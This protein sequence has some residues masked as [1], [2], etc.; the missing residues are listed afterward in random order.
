MNSQRGL[1]GVSMLFVLATLAAC[2]GGGGGGGGAGA[3]PA[4]TFT[5]VF[6]PT[7]M[8]HNFYPFSNNDAKV[9]QLYLA[10]E[11]NG[12]GNI[13]TLRFQRNAENAA[14]VTCPN[15]TI[16][17]G[18]TGAA[19][20][21]STTFASNM[22][23]GQGSSVTVLNNATVTIPAAAAAAWF[24]IPLTTPF[25]YNGVNNLVV[26]IE[27]TTACSVSLAVNTISAASNRRA[28]SLAPDTVPGTAQ[29]STTTAIPLDTRQPLMQFVFAGGDNKIDLGGAAGNSFPFGATAGLR[30]QHLYLASEV[31]GSG[32]ITGVAFQARATTVAGTYT[33]TLRLGHSALAALT[34]TYANNYSG[35][36]TT[37]ANAVANFTIPA[38]VPAGEWIW[39]PI[40]DGVFSYNG[41]DNL[42]VDVSTT[43]GTANNF[44]RTG[45][46]AG[47]RV[48]ANIATATT[49]TVDDF[50]Y[51]IALRFHG[52]AVVKLSA[53]TGN[54]S[55]IFN[56]PN[57]TATLYS[58]TD[59]G[60]AGSVTSV[61]CRLL[62]A[63][64]AASYANFKVV[65]GHAT[66]S[67]LSGTAATDFVSQ[68]TVF[69]GT[70][71]VPAGLLAGDWIDIPLSSAFAYDGK[72][73]LIVWMG[74]GGPGPGTA[75]VNNCRGEFNAT[76]YPGGMGHTVAGAGS[77]LTY[78]VFNWTTDLRMTVQ[79]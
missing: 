4:G 65:M 57:S 2:G 18:H 10:S 13:T 34:D 52:G 61:S 25:Q 41:T 45:T 27:H 20:L 17:L 72:R 33:Y 15:T 63:S 32:P 68:N 9:Q 64:A 66:G 59:L 54:N 14:S 22:D 50:A 43:A 51:H 71:A 30:T 40:P 79:K 49:G 77:A 7:P 60:T 58:S 3:L 78:D 35:S 70:V 62:N 38:G 5:K 48:Y 39:V 24:D 47:R 1:T 69:S 31:N 74:N 53:A 11:I 67:T 6:A 19:A 42:I 12:A 46:V 23:N 36:P 29:H 16:T 76:R 21:A 37:V 44:V 75:V 73:N 28:L 56:G 8:N 26:Q 55:V